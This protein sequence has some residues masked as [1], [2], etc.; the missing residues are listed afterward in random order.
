MVDVVTTARL[1]HTGSDR[2]GPRSIDSCISDVVQALSDHGIVMTTSC[3]SHGKGV[4]EIMCVDGRNV[5]IIENDDPKSADKLRIYADEL[6]Q[7][8]VHGAA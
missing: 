1:S 2:Y 4:A 5:L 7:R 3:C 8:R 6:E